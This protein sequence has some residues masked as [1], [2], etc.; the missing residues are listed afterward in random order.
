MLKIENVTG[1]YINIPVLKNI[2]FEI[3]EKRFN[4]S[5]LDKEKKIVYAKTYYKKSKL[6]KN[7]IIIANGMYLMANLMKG[8][9]AL[10]FADSIIALTKNSKNYFYPAKGY[11]LKSDYLLLNEDLEAALNNILLAE[12]YSIQNV[13]K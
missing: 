13:S 3:L 7:T 10:N 8:E 1:G 5:F 6:Q 11:I 4:N 2:S 9:I 12:K